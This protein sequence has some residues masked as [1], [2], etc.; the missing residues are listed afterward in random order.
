MLGTVDELRDILPSARAPNQVRRFARFK[1][2]TAPIGVKAIDDFADLMPV[3]GED[4]VIS[5]LL[6][7]LRFPVER[8][9]ERHPVIDHHGFFVRDIEGRVGV[10]DVN[11]SGTQDATRSLVLDL[12]TVASRVEHDSNLN[13][14]LVRPDQSLEY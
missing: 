11:A 8:T 2:F 14:A 12:T 9:D 13:G 10:E 4:C 5:G 3:G 7:I 6:E 1:R